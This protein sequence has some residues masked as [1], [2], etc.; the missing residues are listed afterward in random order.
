MST[1]YTTT[2]AVL[3][4]TALMSF[5]L[6]WAAF[7]D[8]YVSYQSLIGW[9]YSIVATA[10]LAAHWENRCTRGDPPKAFWVAWL[11]GLPLGFALLV[12]AIR[13]EGQWPGW[14]AT[15]TA[16]VAD[17]MGWQWLVLGALLLLLAVMRRTLRT[18]S[19]S[20]DA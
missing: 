9:V 4:V 1:G 11:L 7:A 6:P 14:T 13:L 12:L 5:W 17:R 15:T 8:W 19:E 3:G 16:R 18:R 2:R 10:V 20:V